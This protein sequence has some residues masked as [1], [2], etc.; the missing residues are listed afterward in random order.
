MAQRI[1]PVDP[2]DKAAVKAYTR[3]LTLLHEI[4]V[5]T[6]KAKQSTDLK[7]VAELRGLVDRFEKAYIGKQK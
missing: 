1:K 6:M 4:L 3:K 5:T 2:G 7:N